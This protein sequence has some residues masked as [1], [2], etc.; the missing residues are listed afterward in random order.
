MFSVKNHQKSG[1]QRTPNKNLASGSPGL[2]D[3]K[4]GTL[5]VMRSSDPQGP[6]TWGDGAGGKTRKAMR[7]C[8][9]KAASYH[10][11]L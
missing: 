2:H 6:A 10:P 7:G 5:F 8:S 9:K 11:L 1:H 3:L 4:E